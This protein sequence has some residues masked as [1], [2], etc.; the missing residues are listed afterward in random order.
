MRALSLATRLREWGVFLRQARTHWLTT[1]AIAPSSRRLALAMT[2]ALRGRT[3]PGTLRIAEV[4]PGTGSFTR[5]IARGMKP[6]DRLD[7]FDVNEAF[8]EHVRGRVESE[9]AFEGL[10]ISL[11]LEDARTLDRHGPFDVLLS[12]LPFNNFDPAMVES[13]LAAYVRSLNPGGVISFFEYV[14]AR[15]AKG[16]VSS[17][18]RRSELRRL[19]GLL[20]GYLSAYEEA[21][22]LVLPNIPP[23][24]VHHLRVGKAPPVEEPAR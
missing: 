18:A 10:R 6:G 16:L 15:R 24:I 21:S 1:G 8:L 11:H 4:G 20:A 5:E 7:V 23:A 12:G 22:E 3:G 17:S 19:E 2:H 13:I 14:G 9:P